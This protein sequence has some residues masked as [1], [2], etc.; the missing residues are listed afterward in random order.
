MFQ[1]SPS[2]PVAF[3]LAGVLSIVTAI[4][5]SASDNLQQYYPY[6]GYGGCGTGAA[7]PPVP[8]PPVPP[9]LV[10]PGATPVTL[11]PIPAP[12][13]PTPASSPP[14]SGAAVSCFAL[15][16]GAYAVQ[17]P[18]PLVGPTPSAPYPYPISYSS[19]TLSWTAGSAAT[20]FLLARVSASGT[21]I[22]PSSSF[23]IPAGT[24]SY[25]D[26]AL[27]RDPAYCYALLAL[28][29]SQTLAVSNAL[30][31]VTSVSPA[32][33]VPGAAPS[34]FTVQFDQANTPSFTWTPPYAGN[35]GYQLVAL[36]GTG[37]RVITLPGSATRAADPAGTRATCYMLLAT[38]GG[39]LSG[40]TDV[41]CSIPPS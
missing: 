2:K 38:A 11:A 27:G 24:T 35:D 22:L 19:A 17:V 21:T 41:L 29:G 13:T 5:G 31:V 26:T 33:G 6:P 10:P 30:C 36:S 4:G 12:L 18:G 1:R 32:S 7:P 15:S 16:S 14:G 34:N 37:S 8:Y 39:L 3:A 20:A 28:R 9:P 25:S 40:Y 23:V